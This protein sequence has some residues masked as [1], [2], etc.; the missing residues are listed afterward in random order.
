MSSNSNFNVVACID[1]SAIAGAVCDA[2]G[3]VSSRIAAP[4]SL[5]HVLE[6]LETPDHA[7]LSGNI[8][9]G[10]REHLLEELA[11]LDQRRNRLAFEHGKIMLQQAEARVAGIS[12]QPITRIQRHGSLLETLL[13]LQQDSRVFILG[14]SGE[15]HAPTAH[16]LGNQIESLVRGL[17]KPILITTQEFTP[18]ESFLQAYDG[19]D[20]ALFALE[21][22]VNGDLLQGLSCHL[23]MAGKPSTENMDLL[24]A[25]EYKLQAGGFTVVSAVVPGEVQPAIANY[26]AQHRVGMVVMGAYGHS[27]VRQ[28]FIGSNTSKMISMSEV[29]VLLFRE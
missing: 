4:I 6:K 20:S 13:D 10:S 14:R 18:P 2:S 29:P 23:I 3:W 9:L 5:I 24:A 17:S 1:G 22:A 12:S 28:F 16:T 11:E 27:R 21:R 7:D 25:A 15:G 26:V 8:G 19:S